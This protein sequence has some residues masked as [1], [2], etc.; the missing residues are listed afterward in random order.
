MV[1]DWVVEEMESLDLDDKRLDARLRLVLSQLAA[2]P[3]A[4][5]PAAC[6]GRADMTAAYRLFDNEKATFD[7]ILEAHRDAAL[8]RV[9]EQ[10]VVILVQDTT[11]IDLT[12]PEQ[13]VQGAGPLDG[14]TR[15]GA[16]LH[17]LHA[18][19]PDGTPLGTLAA[20]AWARGEQAAASALSRAQRAATPIE[21]K[22]SI[23]WGA[24][25]RQARV[26]AAACPTT[27]CVCVADSESDVYEALLEGTQGSGELDWIVRACQNR[28]LSPGNAEETGTAYLREHLLIAPV[29]FQR[30]IGVRGRES[31]VACE[32]RS[33]RQPRLSRRAQVV[34]RAAQATLRGPKRPQGKLPDVSVNAVLVRE[35]RPPAGEEPIEW[36]L[37]TSLPI[38]SEEQVRLVIQNYCTRWMIEVFFRVLKSGCRVEER[39]FERLDRLLTCAAV[40]LVVAWRTLYVCRLGRGCPDASCEVV[41][42]P[43]EWQ[44][45]WKVVRRTNPPSKPPT[46][47]TVVRIVAEL[48][49]YIHRK[50]SP[51][52]PQTLWLGLQRVHDFAI[53]WES[54]GPSS[55]RRLQHV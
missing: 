29:L 4:S 53:C 25:L 23:R 31:K 36:L 42:E 3:T 54:F 43:A 55:P 46:L 21:E 7:N 1:S 34:V 40:Y 28:A 26:L 49:G 16:L 2:Q 33:R 14:N 41:F 19:T 32:T 45:A 39:R 27:R 20:N 13:V 30:A 9:A 5:I 12:R 10:P 37:L 52:G 24:T 44:A 51:P 38:A 15:V 22:E 48:G 8:T 17:A 35:E 50:N 47:A 18:F 11:E 6:G